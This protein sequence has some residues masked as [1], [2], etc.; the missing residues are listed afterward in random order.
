MTDVER[1]RQMIEQIRVIRNRCEPKS[2]QNPRYLRL[3]NAV[4]APLWIIE[5]LQRED[6][7]PQR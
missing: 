6:A 7:R 2:N 5:D 4:S 3:S 1:L